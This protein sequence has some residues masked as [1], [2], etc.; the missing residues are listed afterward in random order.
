MEDQDAE[1]LRDL[2]DEHGEALFA[3]AVRLTSGDRQRAE[4]L[5]HETLLRA[6]R[7]REGLDE[8]GVT[9]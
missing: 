7:H 6:W 8:M 2:R 4:D 9:R 1:L 3:D 5:V